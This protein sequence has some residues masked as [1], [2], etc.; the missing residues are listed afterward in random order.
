AQIGEAIEGI[1]DVEEGCAAELT[2]QDLDSARSELEGAREQILADERPRGIATRPRVPAEDA[3]RIE[4]IAIADEHVSAEVQAP[5]GGGRRRDGAAHVDG[6]VGEVVRGDF[7]LRF[8]VGAGDAV[9]DGDGVRGGG[10]DA[11]EV[12]REGP[13][14]GHR[15]ELQI[16]V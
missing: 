9:A 4:L 11:E 14:R 12:A 3:L 10:I 16:D 6:R 2:P 15:E 13:R 7:G 8:D 5:Y 1:A